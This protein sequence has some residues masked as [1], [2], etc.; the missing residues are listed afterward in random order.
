MKK[1][2]ID[3]HSHSVLSKHAYSSI[4]ENIEYAS[5]IGLKVYGISEHQP[6]SVDVGAHEW[7]INGCFKTAPKEFN[8]TKILVGVELN[9]LDNG[10]DLHGVKPNELS[11]T[12]ASMH[13]Y[14]Y[15]HNHTYDENTKNYIIACETPYVTIL[16]HID[17]P[18]FPC[19]Y[20]KVIKSAKE[21]NKLIE[22]NN[23]SLDPDGSRKGAKQLDYE[24][25]DLC[26]KYG[27][28]IVLGSDAHIKYEIGNV[29][30]CIDLLEEI[31]FPDELVINFNEDLFNTYFKYR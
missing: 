10:F 4:T 2:L 24:I 9:I 13:G 19:D 21:N 20:E 11:Y 6:D 14:V 12:I 17:Y 28:P 3:L 23:A 5:S 25:L 26:K 18:A 7:A 16:G 27:V 1:N 22:L 31:N 8:G 15:S 29:D 30:R